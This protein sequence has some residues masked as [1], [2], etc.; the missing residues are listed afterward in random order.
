MKPVFFSAWQVHTTGIHTLVDGLPK[1]AEVWRGADGSYAVGDIT[2][3]YDVD[4][5]TDL[6]TYTY[7]GEVYEYE[8]E[9]D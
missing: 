5:E 7:A 2:D 3:I 6:D 4:P 8:V 9:L 1:D